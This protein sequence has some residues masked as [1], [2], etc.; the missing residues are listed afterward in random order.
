MTTVTVSAETLAYVITG[1][2]QGTSYDI[3]VQALNSD[4]DVGVSPGNS[5]LYAK[6]TL[7]GQPSDPYGIGL[8]EPS[9]QDS[10]LLY[11][12]DAS[13]NGGTDIS[14]YN[15]TWRPA[16]G[17]GSATTN[18]NEYTVQNLVEGS[19][20]TFTITA[21]NVSGDLSPGLAKFS[22][23]TNPSNA[24]QDPANFKIGAPPGPNS[25][26]L[27]WSPPGPFP[28]GVNVSAYA[29]T[30]QPPDGGGIA[31]ADKYASS[32]V[33]TGLGANTQYVFNIYT[34]GDSNN[35]QVYSPGNFYV[36]G[37]TTEDG[38]LVAPFAFELVNGSVTTSSAGFIWE[39]ARVSDPGDYVKFYTITAEDG[40]GNTITQSTEEGAVDQPPLTEL[41]FTNLSANTEY[42]FSLTATS[43]F[44][45]TAACT[46]PESISV[47]TDGSGKPSDPRFVIVEG[48]VTTYSVLLNWSA[49]LT[50]GGA[51]ISSYTITW[52]DTMGD[53]GTATTL[54]NVRSYRATGLTPFTYYDFTITARNVGGFVSSG[55]NTSEAQTADLNGPRPPTGFMLSQYISTTSS[56]ISVVWESAPANGGSRI[57]SYILSILGGDINAY[58]DLPTPV[59]EYTFTGLAEKS[60]YQLEIRALNA[61]GQSS[62]ANWW[63]RFTA[64][65]AT[66]GAPGDPGFLRLAPPPSPPVPDTDDNVWIAWN[67]AAANGGTNVSGYEITWTP[68]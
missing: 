16:D 18:L 1:L 28:A 66:D 40:S 7:S 48:E 39:A 33:V 27:E 46:D 50:N 61:S 11:W 30:W 57:A 25:F 44:S 12:T 9:T 45:L 15:I 49:A 23:S 24:K 4:V 17:G 26:G 35:Q 38:G 51:N 37:R 41:T 14:E 55:Q 59:N 2:S 36:I 53:G 58:Y 62:P 68:Q 21:V 47:T 65:T 52:A 8:G 43:D 19:R 22:A 31:Y 5:I 6:T 54:A 10:M 34:V 13:T 67:T 64:T 29:I 42:L 20:Y 63:T 56:S 60:D 3:R 32:A